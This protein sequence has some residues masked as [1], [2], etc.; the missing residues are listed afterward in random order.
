MLEQITNAVWSSSVLMEDA[1]FLLFHGLY[2]H[3]G[4][5]SRKICNI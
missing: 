1:P 3:S 5:Q 4:P 2:Y